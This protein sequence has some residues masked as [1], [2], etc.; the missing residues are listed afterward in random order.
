VKLR[1]G[2]V[3]NSS[4]SS[5]IVAFPKNFK[6]TPEAIKVYLFPRRKALVVQYY[7]EVLSI[8]DAVRRIYAQMKGKHPNSP[9]AIRRALLDGQVPGLPDHNAFPF[10]QP[11]THE[12]NWEAWHRAADARRRAWWKQQA[13]SL[14]P[15]H[16]LYVFQFGDES[17]TAEAILEHAETFRAVPHVVIGHH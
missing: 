5:F 3:S 14:A 9:T 8:D 12:T 4:S 16:D 10:R 1:A 11:G 17:G 2:F 15:G 6:P 7:D 13:A